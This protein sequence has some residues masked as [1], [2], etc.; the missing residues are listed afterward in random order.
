MGPHSVARTRS[1]RPSP[2]MSAQTAAVTIPM[3]RS[4]GASSSVTSTNFPPCCGR[5][6]CAASRA[7]GPG[8]RGPPT[9]RPTLPVPSK[10]AAAATQHGFAARGKRARGRERETPMP[11]VQ[12]EAVAERRVALVVPDAAAD[13]EA[14]RVGR[15]PLA[16]KNRAP[17]SSESLA[18]SAHGCSGRGLEAAVGLAEEEHAGLAVRAADEDV[19]Q[20]V[21]V[22]VGDGDRGAVHSLAPRQQALAPELIG[23]LV[24]VREVQAAGVG[25]LGEQ[26]G[27]VGRAVEVRRRAGGPSRP[28]PAPAA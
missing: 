24:R 15:L 6:S 9:K 8:R 14:G 1:G 3:F 27:R 13:D 20:A 11:V 12:V 10:S 7:S 5:G 22:H 25:V 21:A 17:T 23:G 19:G 18:A 4:P 26:C 2:S 28:A 16:S